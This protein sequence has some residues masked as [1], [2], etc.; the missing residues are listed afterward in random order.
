M[1]TSRLAS[2]QMSTGS[3]SLVAPH[4]ASP[5]SGSS[6]EDLKVTR[7]EVVVE[8]NGDVSESVDGAKLGS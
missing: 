4:R 6:V 3:M 2:R 1:P 7:D 8:E 5:P